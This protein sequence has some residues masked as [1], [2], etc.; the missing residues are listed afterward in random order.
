MYNFHLTK[1]EKE[2]IC[3]TEAPIT[4]LRL[5]AYREV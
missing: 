4:L 5:S 2:A 3:E 1:Y